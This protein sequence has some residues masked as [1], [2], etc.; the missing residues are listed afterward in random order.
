VKNKIISLIGALSMLFILGLSSIGCSPVLGNTP[1]TT[2]D[3]FESK[4]VYSDLV[5]DFI[6]NSSTFKFDGIA[7]SINLVKGTGPE[8]DMEFVIEFQ[9][10]HA[11]HGDRA[12]HMLAQVVTTY[13]VVLSVKDGQIYSAVCDNS[14]DILKNAAINAPKPEVQAS[15][16]QEFTLPVGQS[17][18][19]PSEN[20]VVKFIDVTSD[21]RSPINAQTIWT[22]EASIRIQVTDQDATSEMTLTE[23]GSIDGFTQVSVNNYQ[24]YFQLKPYP[25]VG[26]QPA[27]EAYTLILKIT[28]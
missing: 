14:W 18:S 8:N 25:V 20:L 6:K 17:A 5:T 21:S 22:G 13:N 16:G 4:L 24:L 2:P 19:I 1:N 28:K 12:G 9:T 23:K 3:L 11:G 26:Q 10:N 7:D 27:A 15:M